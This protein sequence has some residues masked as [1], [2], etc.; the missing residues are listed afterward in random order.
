MSNMADYKINLMFIVF[1]SSIIYLINWSKDI[2][3]LGLVIA[4]SIV[5]YGIFLWVE[6]KNKSISTNLNKYL[7]VPLTSLIF[8]LVFIVCIIYKINDKNNLIS[9]GRI[10]NIILIITLSIQ[11]ICLNYSLIVKNKTNFN[12]LSFICLIISTFIISTIS[13]MFIYNI[14]DLENREYK[15][16]YSIKFNIDNLTKTITK[17]DTIFNDKILFKEASAQLSAS[18]DEYKIQKLVN[19]IQ[20]RLDNHCHITVKLSAFADIRPL[21]Y[22]N[23]RYASNYELTTERSNRLKYYILSNL[24]NKINDNNI[25]KENLHIFDGRF[26]TEI[27]SKKI[28]NE[29]RKVDIFAITKYSTTLNIQSPELYDY[30]YYSILTII[31]TGNGDVAPITKKIKTYVIIESLYGLLF[32]SFLLSLLVNLIEEK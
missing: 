4:I 12:F 5:F 2:S 28:D 10:I 15:K 9:I 8:V 31:N 11:F 19:N 24:L 6:Y 14:N 27:A 16:K 23:N 17:T 21:K 30:F 29:D 3:E 32:F 26:S 13:F 7:I 20:K 1:T 18:I 25:L 22:P